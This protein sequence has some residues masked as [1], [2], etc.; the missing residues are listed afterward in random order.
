MIEG[1]A[2][3]TTDGR[4]A[5]ALRFLDPDAIPVGGDPMGSSYCWFAREEEPSYANRRIIATWRSPS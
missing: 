3:S 4:L 5:V 2:S 1:A